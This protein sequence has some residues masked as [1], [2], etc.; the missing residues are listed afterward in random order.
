MTH[1][2]IK[3]WRAL[4]HSAIIKKPTYLHLW[5]IILLM[6]SHRKSK[7]IISGRTYHLEPGQFITGRKKLAQISGIHESTV[8]RILNFLK[9][10]HFIEQQTFSKFRIITVKNWDKFQGSENGEQVFEQQANNKRTQSRSNKEIKKKKD[11]FAFPENTCDT[12]PI[13]PEA[14]QEF[15]R[16]EGLI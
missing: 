10:G 3:L 2:W 15:L 4:L 11:G 8:Q 13:T 14:A 1:G 12:Q 9:S 16:A 6:A 5:I 7:V